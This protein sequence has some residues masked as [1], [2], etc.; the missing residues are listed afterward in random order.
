MVYHYCSLDT[1][2]NIIRNHTLRLSD[3]CNSTDRLEMK[4]LLDM[5]ENKVKLIYTNRKEEDFNDSVIY[6]MDLDDAFLLLLRSVIN[7]MKNESD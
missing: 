6:G 4:V 2:L 1:F 3:L 5:I 7:K